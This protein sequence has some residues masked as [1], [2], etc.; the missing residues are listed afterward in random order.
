MKRDAIYRFIKNLLGIIILS[1]GIRFILSD[2]F[3]HNIIYRSVKAEYI[4]KNKDSLSGISRKL[5]VPLLHIAA[6]NNIDLMEESALTAGGKIVIPSRLRLQDNN[7]YL[8][9]QQRIYDNILKD[10]EV[11]KENIIKLKEGLSK[12][13]KEVEAVK[14]VIETPV[15][16][17]YPDRCNKVINEYNKIAEKINSEKELYKKMQINLNHLSDKMNEIN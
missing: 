11:K 9:R 8:E 16:V 5:N 13:R 17:S 6:A 4:I 2:E 15:G 3:T 10:L 12:K 14:A 7:A 1:F